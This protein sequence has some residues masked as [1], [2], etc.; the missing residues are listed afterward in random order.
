MQYPGTEMR[1]RVCLITG[2]TNGIGKVTALELARRGATVAIVSRSAGRG[3]ATLDEIKATSGN[4]NVELFVA[5]LSSQAGVR[6]LAAGFRA[7]HDRLHVLVNNAGAL[8]LRRRES[9]DGL[10]LTFAL[11]HM[12]YFLLTTSL[13]D[14]LEASAPARIVNV[15]SNAHYRGHINFDNLQAKGWF[16]WGLGA[17]SNSKL[18]NVL[19][20]YELARRLAGSGVTANAVHPGFVATGFAHNNGLLVSLGMLPIRPFMISAW[21][22][23]Q[24]L[25][26]LAA[27]P[28]AEGISGKFFWRHRDTRSLAESYDRGIQT[29]L[30]QVSEA[31]AQGT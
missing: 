25:I 29:R 10:E 6:Q 2:A 19:F 21:Q 16:Y 26:W 17:Y 5:D 9:V 31:L 27:S 11:N 13:L 23:A 22:G 28:E 24:P 8:N 12:A 3:A 1:G 7:A 14:L 30:W 20:T 4:E 15:S 18:A